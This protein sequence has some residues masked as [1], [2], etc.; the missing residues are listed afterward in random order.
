MNIIGI[1]PG[2]FQP[3]TVDNLKA[4]HLLKKY[5]GTNTFVA[6]DDEVK[7]PGFP[8]NFQDKQ[9]IWTRHGVPIDKIVLTKDPNS[10]LEITRKFGPDRTVVLFAMSKNDASIALKTPNGKFSIFKGIDSSVEPMNKKAYILVIPDQT[11]VINKQVTPETMRKAFGSKSMDE[12]KKKS[13]FKQV[14]GWYDISL[15]DFVKKKFA[16]ADVVKERVCESVTPI[17]RRTLKTFVKETFG[18]LTSPKGTSDAENSNSV[19]LDSLSPT[20]KS[21]LER[22]KRQNDVDNIK[23]KEAELGV[24]KK[25]RDFQREKEKVY[26]KYT[27]PSLTKNIQKLKSGL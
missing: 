9:Q 3:P 24:A 17:I 14:F 7:L 21:K 10:A 2:K 25:E 15:F 5:T 12:E 11:F 16:E 4:Y 18:Q 6:T 27:I 26:N 13:F 22:E 1:Y 8:L 20:E 19:P 23:Q